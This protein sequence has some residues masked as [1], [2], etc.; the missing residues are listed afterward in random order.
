LTEIY[1]KA[2]LVENK[3]YSGRGYVS[4]ENREVIK[5]MLLKT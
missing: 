3:V 2:L 5:E 1:A 4:N